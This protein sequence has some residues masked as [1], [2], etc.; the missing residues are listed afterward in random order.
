MLDK[1]GQPGRQWFGQALLPWMVERASQKQCP[2]IVVDAIA[3]RAIWHRMDRMLEKPG[4]IAHGEKMTE[5][6]FW[7]RLCAD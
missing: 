7:R 4:V 2:G 5:L 3:V 1:G 6:H